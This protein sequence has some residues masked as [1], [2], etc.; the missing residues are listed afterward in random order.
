MRKSILLGALVVVG[1]ACLAPNASARET[2]GQG[3][4]TDP[5]AA[6]PTPTCLIRGSDENGRFTKSVECV[7]LGADGVGTGRY[8]PGGATGEHW[9]TVS[10]QYLPT[11]AT[12]VAWLPLDSVTQHGTGDLTAT[13]K[14]AAATAVGTVRACLQSG[15]GAAPSTD[16]P[17]LGLVSQ[18]C[19]QSR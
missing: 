2:A 1:L 17:T 15:D 5:P 19:S 4:P 18:I 12:S 8:S 16:K 9:M 3:V 11:N 7:V 10:L 14:P 13:T 6:T